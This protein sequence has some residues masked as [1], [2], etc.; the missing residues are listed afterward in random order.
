MVFGLTSKSR[1]LCIDIQFD[2]LYFVVVRK[3]GAYFEIDF[4]QKITLGGGVFEDGHVRTPGKVADILY[5]IKKKFGI[6]SVLVSIPEH[7]SYATLLPGEIYSSAADIRKVAKTLIVA[8][9]YIWTN[10]FKK[11]RFPYTVLHA[12]DKKIC[13]AVYSLIKNIG[14]RSITMYP[15]ALVLAEVE[16]LEDGLLCDIQ[17]NQ[18]VLLSVYNSRAIHFSIVPYGSSML[19]KKIQEKF[20][21]SDEEVIEVCS[22]YGT[23][24]LPRKEGHVVH[25]MVHTFLAP[26]IDEMQSLT[27]RRTEHSLQPSG[28]LF[29]S[30]SFAKY[31]GIGEDLARVARFETRL[32]NVWEGLIDFERYIPG[33]HKNDSYQY[34]G[35]TGLMNILKKGTQYE[36]FDL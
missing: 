5:E 3:E 25:G 1:Y 29:V 9:A 32:I 16:K 8:P 20:S 24:V 23:D 7:S 35:I 36:P 34:V 10:T 2:E 28:Q 21:L 19:T 6:I 22:A 33:I 11:E 4:T 12:S 27:L 30:G 31:S 17:I 13:D 18:I 14:L 15:R 26:I